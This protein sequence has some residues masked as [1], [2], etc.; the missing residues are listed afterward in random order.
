MFEIEGD[1][2]KKYDKNGTCTKCGYGGIADVHKDAESQ[3]YC[4]MVNNFAKMGS[5]L[6]VPREPI[7]EHIARTCKNCGYS[8]REKPMDVPLFSAE[9]KRCWPNKEEIRKW[10]D[11][12]ADVVAPAVGLPA[13]MLKSRKPND[14]AWAIVNEPGSTSK[15]IKEAIAKSACTVSDDPGGIRATCEAAEP[16]NPIIEMGDEIKL[17]GPVREFLANT[18]CDVEHVCKDGRILVKPRHSIYIEKGAYTLIRKGPKVHTF[19]HVGVYRH[20]NG[21]M[22]KVEGAGHLVGHDNLTVTITATEESAK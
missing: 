18:V 17:N 7:P 8:W 22:I 3:A 14:P 16:D 4:N 12:L 10:M 1:Q 19:K 15:A 5:I 2:M 11:D 13:E 6:A 20:G 21:A 9:Y